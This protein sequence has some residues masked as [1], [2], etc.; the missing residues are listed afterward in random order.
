[1]E[2]IATLAQAIPHFEYSEAAELPAQAPQWLKEVATK[3]VQS[4]KP[5]IITNVPWV[6]TLL[7]ESE[8]CAIA[9]SLTEFM[10]D[11]PK[12]HMRDSAGRAMRKSVDVDGETAEANDFLQSKFLKLHPKGSLLL[13]T[14][15]SG[16]TGEKHEELASAMSLCNFGI[17][18]N[19]VHSAGEKGMVWCGRITVVGTRQVA[20]ILC[21][22]ILQFMRSSGIASV[23]PK[24][25]WRDIRD[26]GIKKMIEAGFEA[27]NI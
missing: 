2:I 13:I 1:M 12:S 7:A 14:A 18:S 21:S 15:I 4:A 24:F 6:Q 5:Y 26:E 23:D 8:T 27:R 19:S 11:F 16:L 10:T 9:E 3:E 22:D 20:M 25:C 17:R